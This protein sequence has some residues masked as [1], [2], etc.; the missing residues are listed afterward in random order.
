MSRAIG[1]VLTALLFILM[2]SPISAAQA[3]ETAVISGQ[4][5]DLKGKPIAGVELTIAGP[6]S[7]EIVITTVSTDV[8]GNWSYTPTVPG[9]YFVTINPETL[10]SGVG[11]TEPDKTTKS[12]VL[13]TLAKSPPPIQFL[14]GEG[15]IR[16][17]KFDI[18]QQLL[19]DGVLLSIMMS[20]AAVGLSLIFGTTGLTNFA[21]GEIITMGGLGTYMFNTWFGIHVIPAA[22]LAV[23]MS[24]LVSGFLQDRF[25][26]KPLRKRGTGVI[27]MLVVSIGLGI[28]IR[29]L[30]LY[31]FGGD[32]L[33][34]AQFAGQAGWQIGAVSLTP[35]ALISALIGVVLL[36]FAIMWLL[37]STMGKASRA[38]ADNPALASASGIDV[39]KVIQS[40]WIL[41]AMLAGYAGVM[42]GL[43]QG[44][45]FIMGSDILLLIFAA[46]T[47]GGLGTAYG[48]IVGSFIVG[49]FI[50]LSTLVIP[51]ELKFVGALVVLIL[52]LLVRP[53]GIMGSKERVG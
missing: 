26:W 31:I 21:H 44:V 43:N 50:Q 2:L 29:Y 51:S 33:Q 20:L 39:E 8:A 19:V 49:I 15:P 14:T 41:G 1:K 12:V 10:P 23:G 22:I 35:K 30:Y 40:V 42:M 52:I 13:F 45:Q 9:Q 28:L 46:V 37:K 34:Y 47:L 11:L 25:I 38:V 3:D 48:A 7:Q 27:A 5:V 32:R 4:I 18:A 17:S 24:M 53:Q 36:V 16:A 6:N